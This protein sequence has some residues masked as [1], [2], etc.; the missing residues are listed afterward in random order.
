M[1]SDELEVLN[2][3]HMVLGTVAL[4]ESLQSTA[5]KTSALIAEPNESFPEQIAL[6]LQEGTVLAAWQAA[7]AVRLRK[8]LLLQVVLHRQI[9][10]TYSAVDPAGSNESLFHL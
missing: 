1:L 9:A 7:G 5:G 4:V 10:D 6:L 3:A 2:H 8:S